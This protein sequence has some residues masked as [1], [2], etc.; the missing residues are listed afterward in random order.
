MRSRAL[1]SR[2]R[3][4]RHELVQPALAFGLV[5][6]LHGNL[7]QLLPRFNR[8]AYWVRITLHE[9]A[10]CRRRGGALPGLRI[11]FGRAPQRLALDLRRAVAVRDALELAGGP[12]AV[13]GFHVRDGELRR[14]VGREL[15]LRVAGAKILEHRSRALPVAHLDQRRTRIVFGRSADRRRRRRLA[16]AQE[17]A[18]GDVELA[19]SACLLALFVDRRSDALDDFAV[20]R[21]GRGHEPDQARVR[22]LGRRE[23]REIEVRMSNDRPCRPLERRRRRRRSRNE[24]SGDVAG[25]RELAERVQLLGRIRLHARRLLV[26]RIRVDEP[27]GALDA[28]LMPLGFLGT[29][30]H[31]FLLRIR[32]QRG[33]TGLAT[34]RVERIRIRSALVLDGGVV[35]V[36]ALEQHFGQQEVRLG[37]VLV[38]WER[39]QIGAVP[40]R[41]RRV[42]GLLVRLL[43]LGVMVRGEIRHVALQVPDDLWLLLERV[44]RPVRTARTVGRRRSSLCPRVRG[45]HNRP[46]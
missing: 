30:Q 13:A 2:A 5:V 41:G 9:S 16:Y 22:G 40:T 20:L 35:E 24:R 42:F 4:R 18:H 15:M 43:R 8:F 23:I 3:V 39:L 21:I 34:V 11:Q 33:V 7:E 19:R 10:V 1:R 32:E 28:L 29:L 31:L 25:A 27:Q 36:A 44:P 37:G 45:R 14:H 38:V 6:G 46:S 12:R 26:H 17:V